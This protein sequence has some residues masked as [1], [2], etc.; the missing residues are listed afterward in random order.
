[1]RDHIGVP[2]RRTILRRGLS[3]ASCRIPLLH[4]R[5]L[6]P[7][8]GACCLRLVPVLALCLTLSA[9]APMKK[10][11]SGPSLTGQAAEVPDEA[12]LVSV[13]GTVLPAWRVL[14]WLAL[15]CDRT[16]E[17]HQAAGTVPDWNAPAGG[18]SV[19]GAADGGAV[20]LSDHAKDQALADALLYAETEA[21]S[22]Q[23]GVTLDADDEAALEAQWAERCEAHGGE[24]AYLQLLSRFGLDRPRSMELY[25]T[26]RL[27]GKL[28]ALC[29]EG[30]GPQPSDQ[31]Y[32]ALERD[33]GDIRFDRILAAGGDGN[34]NGARTKAAAYFVRLNGAADQAALFTEL[35]AQGDDPAGPRTL[36]AGMLDEKLEAALRAL[37]IGQLSGIVE[38]AEGFSIL[39]R[40]PPE[41]GPLLD[42]WLDRTLEEAASAAEVKVSKAWRD[43]DAGAFAARLEELRAGA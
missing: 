19:G 13:D 2:V 23:Y 36:S 42:A 12:A 33:S 11:P 28:C 14:Y 20:T 4:P 29:R 6:R 27:Y 39:R 41:R 5:L 15:A 35:A 3:Q 24:A 1:M 16:R 37:E 34:G 40:L 25:R 22:E 31:Q 9:C 38:S 21:L 30:G 43:L 18:N 32:A 7:W 8:H 26:G 17:E 10:T